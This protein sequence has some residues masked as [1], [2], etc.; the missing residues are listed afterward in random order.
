MK[1]QSDREV[2]LSC[3]AGRQTV[4]TPKASQADYKRRKDA[5]MFYRLI[6]LIKEL[7]AEVV[8]GELIDF[9]KGYTDIE[10]TVSQYESDISMVDEITKIDGKIELLEEFEELLQSGLY[11]ND[12]I[13]TTKN[14][15]DL[16][17]LDYKTRLNDV[18][19]ETLKMYYIIKINTL[20]E[21]KNRL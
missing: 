14:V 16:M 9:I 3:N 19:S 21:V 6:E 5:Q 11:L 17:L 2:Y 15:V 7:P 18:V 1:S 20:N 13:P 10:K 8:K 4:T 12:M